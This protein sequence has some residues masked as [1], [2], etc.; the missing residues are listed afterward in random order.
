[1]VEKRK[2]LTSTLVF[3]FLIIA[4]IVFAFPFFL[5]IINSFKSNGEILQSPFSLPNSYSFDQFAMA[6]EKMNFLV[7][8]KNSLFITLLSTVFI[9]L[10][11]GMAAYY[12]VRVKTK[13]NN[14]LFAILVASMIIPFQSIMIPLINIYGAKLQWID[15]APMPLLVA[16]YIG[17]GSSLS[18]F[19]FHGFIKSIPF[20]LEEAASIDG[21]S[22]R[23]IF[24]KIIFPVL[25]PTSVTIGILN[26]MWIWNDYL[27]PSLILNKDS[28]YT[29]P[30]Q[31]KVFNGTY[32]NNWELLIPAILITILPILVFYLIG[33]RMIIEGIT[34]GSVK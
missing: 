6:I 10:L 19:I 1:M 32:M 8:L 14:T 23:Q 9:L 15:S 17:F 18:V 29:L 13:F 28:L 33:Q 25:M 3:A 21:C 2:A 12:I 7:T 27:L 16:L 5:L 24:F 22:P 34:Q 20:E 4:L 30:I 11:S 26:V 31:M